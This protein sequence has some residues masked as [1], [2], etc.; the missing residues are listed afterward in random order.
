LLPFPDPVK[1]VSELS[2]RVPLETL[3]LT[4]TDSLSESATEILLPLLA[5]K[6][7]GVFSVVVSLPISV[8]MSTLQL[9]IFPGLVAL[10][11]LL[12]SWLASTAY[13]FQMPL[14]FFLLKTERV[15]P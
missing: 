15:E 4:S 1:P 11:A 13:N 2:V 3:R 14:G 6:M 10:E 7:R 12:F 9:A 5:E 8:E